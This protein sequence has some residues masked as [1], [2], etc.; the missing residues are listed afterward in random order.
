MAKR[1]KFQATKAKTKKP[2]RAGAMIPGI[3]L[4]VLIAAAA[5]IFVWGGL[6][7]NGSS[8][9]P[10]VRLAGVEVGGMNR[11]AA[12]EAVE[13]A[14]AEAYAASPLEVVLPDRTIV[15]DP[16]QTNVALDAEHA[17]NEAM[18]YGRR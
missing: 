7:K 3:L 16:K 10:N 18:A 17:V 6:L 9:Y 14:V 12:R 11:I 4:L 1:G 13:S 5:G 15:L 2:K 8:I